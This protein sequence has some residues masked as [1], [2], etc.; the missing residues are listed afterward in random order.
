MK[1]FW[2]SLAERTYHDNLQYLEE[3]WPESVVRNF[4]SRVEEIL[5]LLKVDPEIFRLWDINGV[6]R[7]A[8]INKHTSL[9][10]SYDG[11]N[12][13]IL[14]FWNHKRNPHILKRFLSIIFV[15]S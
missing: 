10:Y 5:A 14:L 11:E 12:I 2:T 13:F 15:S 9:F 7:I 8:L 1:I 3:D 4:I 6:A